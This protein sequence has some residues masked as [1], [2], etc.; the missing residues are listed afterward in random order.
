MSDAIQA[1]AV[2]FNQH[3]KATHE[4][5]EKASNIQELIEAF[6][7][8]DFLRQGIISLKE[9]A[10]SADVE[11]DLKESLNLIL[12]IRGKLWSKKKSLHYTPTAEQEALFGHP[13]FKED[14]VSSPRIRIR[15]REFAIA[16][17]R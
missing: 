10:V 9:N 15:D 11:L 7:R 5:L 14:K 8:L 3:V 1:A 2:E 4:L 16:R 17:C 6:E 12:K 13:A